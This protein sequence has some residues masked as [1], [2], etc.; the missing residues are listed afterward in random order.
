MIH[1]LRIVLTIA[2]VQMHSLSTNDAFVYRHAISVRHCIGN[3]LTNRCFLSL[4]NNTC[5]SITGSKTSFISASWNDAFLLTS[6]LNKCT[7]VRCSGWLLVT[8]YSF[9]LLP[10]ESFIALYTV[11]CF[12]IAAARVWNS[13][14]QHVTSMQSLP[15]FRS[16][17][18]T[19]LF[20][21]CFPWLIVF[22]TY[23]LTSL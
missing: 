13:L 6:P 1:Q 5:I 20:R 2:V 15:V 3:H 21:R 7:V 14:P 12:P 8:R 11:Y 17:L 16:R 18:K 4:L 23:L 10:R 19:H 9:N 22:L